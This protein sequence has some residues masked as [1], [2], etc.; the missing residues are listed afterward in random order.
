METDE[1][2]KRLVTLGPSMPFS[3]KLHRAT[4]DGTLSSTHSYASLQGSTI[5]PVGRE[6]TT[7]LS[8]GIYKRMKKESRTIGPKK[9]GAKRLDSNL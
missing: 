9:D 8:K 2:G 5:P 4:G 6:E 3:K 1:A 7:Q